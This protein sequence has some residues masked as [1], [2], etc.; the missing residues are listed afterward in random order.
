MQSKQNDKKGLTMDAQEWMMD[1]KYSKILGML[2]A[3]ADQG[4]ITNK[5]HEALVGLITEIENYRDLLET[6]LK[7]TKR[8]KKCCV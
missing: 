3:L 1:W 2:D 6:E 8:S 7:K 4:I 5:T